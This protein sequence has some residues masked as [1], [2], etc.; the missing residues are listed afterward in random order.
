MVDHDTC[1]ASQKLRLDEQLK[2]ETV[3][4]ELVQKANSGAD[5]D[6]EEPS[7]QISHSVSR[8][9]DEEISE[10]SVEKANSPYPLIRRAKNFKHRMFGISNIGNTCFFNATMQCLNATEAL[11]EHY[12]LSI[13][14]YK[15][16]SD[17]LSKF[18]RLTQAECTTISI[19]VMPSSWPKGISTNMLPSVLDQCL[20]PCAEYKINTGR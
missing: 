15:E 13:D 19:T 12:I 18:K 16:H 6:D 14:E 3:V 5:D 17:A 1:P 2:F 10:L 11:V 9:M 7:D 8:K 4:L 20:T